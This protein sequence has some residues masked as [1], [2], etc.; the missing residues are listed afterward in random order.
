MGLFGDQGQ[1]S[2]RFPFE[3]LLDMRPPGPDE[4]RS[5]IELIR[6]M[7]RS[8]VRDR[9]RQEEIL[10]Q[11][12]TTDLSDIYRP[13]GMDGGGYPET[14]DLI[15]LVLETAERVGYFY[16]HIFNRRRPN[17]VDVRL[18]PFIDVPPHAAFPSNHAFQMFSVAEVF[19]RILPEH[20]GSPELFYVAQRVAENREFAGLH[21]K[22]DTDAGR[23]LAQRFAPYLV[24]ALRREIGRALAEWR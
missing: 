3:R 9:I 6:D 8:L 17:E 14:E 4:T 1:Y 22:S 20:P 10:R 11:A 15:D 12:D 13:L 16:K 5:E 7:Q 21:Y 23:R 19:S 24:V 18:R 2:M